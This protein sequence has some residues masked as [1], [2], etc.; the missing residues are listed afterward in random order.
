MQGAL[1]GNELSRLAAPLVYWF[2]WSDIHTNTDIHL[3]PPEK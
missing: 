3:F 2:A 1:E